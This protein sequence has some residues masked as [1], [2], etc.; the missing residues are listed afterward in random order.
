VG[1]RSTVGTGVDPEVDL[2]KNIAGM[3]SQCLQHW[4]GKFPR[5]DSWCKMIIDLR[6]NQDKK[7]GSCPP[8]FA[9]WLISFVFQFL[10]YMNHRGKKKKVH[11][12]WVPQLIQGNTIYW[13]LLSNERPQGWGSIVEGHLWKLAIWQG[14]LHKASKHTTVVHGGKM[15]VLLQE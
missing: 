9:G 15:K 6:S 3:D 5:K 11:G 4:V 8:R 2:L 1:V 10:P 7:T 14:S 12:C 13:S